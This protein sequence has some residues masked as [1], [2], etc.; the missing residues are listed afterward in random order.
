MEFPL[1]LLADEGHGSAGRRGTRRTADA[2]DIIFGV[3]RHV[4]I[5]DQS[6]V[7]DVNAARH[8]VGGHEDRDLVVLEVEH[9]LLALGLLQIGVHGRHVE[10]HAFER[11]GQLLDLHLRRRE[12][13]RLRLGRLGEHL[14]DDVQ[15]LVLIADIG[16]L[17]DSLVGF[18]NGDIHLGGIAQNGLGQFAD[19][20]GQR[21]REHDRLPLLWHVRDD[22]H[23]VLA[24]THVEHAVG[25]VEN[26]AFDMRE[27]DA[28]VL[29]MRNHAAGSGDDHVRPHQHT[30][31]LHVPALAV[32]AAVNDRGR[33]GQVIGKALKLLVYLLRQFARG[34]D[35]HRFYHIVFVAFEQQPVQQRQRVGRRLARSR[36]RASDDVAAFENHRD[37]VFL[38]RSH[39]L[40][41]HIVESV[42]DLIL[43]L[44]FVKSHFTYLNF[45][46]LKF[47]LR[48]ASRECSP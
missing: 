17:V 24:E 48:K 41:I 46:L 11:M 14:A 39:L 33:D 6:D 3:V 22:L 28:A 9:H 4:V 7:L 19:L 18:R 42:E 27:V 29:D 26:Q 35:D 38:H 47:L 25:F 12:D 44:K 10:F 1:F 2:V 45:I 15:L 20:R 31:L 37:R 8:D 21:R 43:Q 32:A 40:K 5:D 36:L 34:H 16:R 30:P 13:D 23:D